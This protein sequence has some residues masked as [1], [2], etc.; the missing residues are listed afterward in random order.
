MYF[1]DRC[2]VCDSDSLVHWPAVTSPF[3]SQIVQWPAPVRCSLA[4]CLRCGHRFYD[5]RLDEAEMARVYAGY[6]GKDYFA[7]RHR[8]EP[9]YT[10]AVNDSIG[11]DQRE[12]DSRR[13]YVLEFLRKSLPAS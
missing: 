1:V 4:E 10:A 3:I 12:I 5:L 11:H 2:V 13:G 8:W 9:W 7:V 6:R